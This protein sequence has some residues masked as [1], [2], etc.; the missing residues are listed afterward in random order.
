MIEVLPGDNLI[1]TF[2]PSLMEHLAFLTSFITV[3][4]LIAL[5]L[6]QKLKQVLF[7]LKH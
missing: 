2:R 5:A 6:S 3:S 1:I 4:V 7:L